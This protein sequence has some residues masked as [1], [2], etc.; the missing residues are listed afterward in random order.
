MFATVQ[1]EERQPQ[2]HQP[3]THSEE[4]VPEANMSWALAKARSG[5]SPFSEKVKD[6]LT[7]KFD[8]G[9]KT[10]QK[11]SAEQVAKDMRNA[12]TH[13]NQRLL[14]R[15]DWLT[16]SVAKDSFL[17]WHLQE[18]S[19]VGTGLT[20]AKRLTKVTKLE[21]NAVLLKK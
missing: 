6:Y 15:E 20:R 3:C 1:T 11:V 7:K 13:D 21:S 17:T 19:R 16:K 12:R 2:H 4:P 18:E 14:G 5:S 10:G 8:I 9:E